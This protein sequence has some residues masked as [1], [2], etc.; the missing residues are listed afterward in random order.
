MAVPGGFVGG[1]EL[2]RDLGR[3]AGV[4]LVDVEQRQQGAVGQEAVVAQLLALRLAQRDGAHRRAPRQLVVEAAQE[5]GVAVGALAFR[6]LERL[7]LGRDAVQ[8]LL[9]Q[10]HV[11]EHELQQ[12]VLDVAGRV[13]ALL[14]V[15]DGVVVERAHDVDQRV[16]LAQLVEEAQLRAAGVAARPDGPAEGRAG[17][18][19]VA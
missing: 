10:P 1:A 5:G 2:G 19:G 18:V 8:A 17:K 12:H 7:R 16:L 15:R 13:D 6:R 3:P 9:D 11:G 14:G 4:G